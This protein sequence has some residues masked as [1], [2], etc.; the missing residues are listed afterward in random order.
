MS[1]GFEFPSKH[2]DVFAEP[3]LAWIAHVVTPCAMQASKRLIDGERAA[4]WRH[5]I[6]QGVSP[7]Y[8]VTHVLAPK[9]ATHQA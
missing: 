5:T 7:G 6:A 3:L 9:V 4:K 1:N 2:P 8:D